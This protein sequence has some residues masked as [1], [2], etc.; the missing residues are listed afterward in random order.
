[1]IYLDGAILLVGKVLSY[2][3]LSHRVKPTNDLPRL[4]TKPALQ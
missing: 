3:A 2:K 1:M 4:A